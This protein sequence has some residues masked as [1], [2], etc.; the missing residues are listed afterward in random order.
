MGAG[1]ARI[2]DAD[3]GHGTYTPDT[4]KAGSPNV[5]ANGIGVAR[6]G[7]NHG[8]HVNTVK[9]YDVHSTVCGT[10]SATV[11]INGNSI[12]RIGDPV[13]LAT[14]AVGSGNVFAGG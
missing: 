5:F 6:T 2:G 8:V 1:A 9:P 3:T 13:D 11:L 12:F 14:Q 4:V 10:G 7:D